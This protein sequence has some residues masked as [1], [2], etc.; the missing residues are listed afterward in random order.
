MT[1]WGINPAFQFLLKNSSK[2]KVPFSHDRARLTSHLAANAAGDL[3]PATFVIKCATKVPTDQRKT[4]VIH[5]LNQQPGFTEAEGWFAGMWSRKLKDVTHYR[6]YL[7]N[8]LDGRLVF[9]QNY[10]YMDYCGAAMWCDL[11]VAPA[12]KKSGRKKWLL[13]WDGHKSHLNEEVV[14][15]FEAAGVMLRSL[16]PN[17]TDIL[18][19]ALRSPRLSAHALQ[20]AAHT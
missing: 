17:M 18:Q 1:Q 20:H 11:V 8:E 7:L 14:A 12:L 5:T 3:L 13:V 2:A 15:I 4:T 6:P 16:P 10:A 19:G 9:A